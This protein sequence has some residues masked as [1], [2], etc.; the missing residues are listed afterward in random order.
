M[1][2]FKSLVCGILVLY[3]PKGPSEGLTYGRSITTPDPSRLRAGQSLRVDL[4]THLSIDLSID[5][6]T[7]MLIASP[8]SHISHLVIVRAKLSTT[9]SP[10]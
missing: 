10:I 8:I 3:L 7:A 1:E 4:S 5:L 2:D 6:L 9:H